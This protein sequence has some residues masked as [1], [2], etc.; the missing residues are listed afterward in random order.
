[1]T[2]KIAVIGY[3][4]TKN[5]NLDSD[6]ERWKLNHRIDDDFSI[7]FNMHDLHNLQ[8]CDALYQFFQGM[9][10]KLIT[11]KE[12]LDIFPNATPYPIDE[13]LTKY[14]D[15][16]YFQN[17]S[18]DDEIITDKEENLLT[19][20]IAEM[21]IYAIETEGITDI[22]LLGVDMST[23]NEYA[24]QLMSCIYCLGIAQG[25]GIKIHLPKNSKLLK[26]ITDKFYYLLKG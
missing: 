24:H 15:F 4:Q 9:G 21:L 26:Q 22:A 5:Q 20:S 25:K 6:W 1:M 18:N 13:I 16:E 7:W 12:N 10:S 19:N 23:S 3:A 2:K 14:F 8:P 11:C 17:E